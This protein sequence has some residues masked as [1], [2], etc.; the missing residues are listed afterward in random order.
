M[1]SLCGGVGRQV[2]GSS[3]KIPCPERVMALWGCGCSPA[4]HSCQGT[5]DALRS[6]RAVSHKAHPWVSV[7]APLLVNC[8]IPVPQFPDL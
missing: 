4:G 6:R 3:L 2:T 1:F 7:P 8:A 5:G